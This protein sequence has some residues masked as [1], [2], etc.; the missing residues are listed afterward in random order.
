[1]ETQHTTSAAE[2]PVAAE[3]PRGFQRMLVVTDR[4]DAG[5]AAFALARE[6]AG[7]FG[8]EIRVLEVSEA[9]GATLGARNRHLAE[10]IAEAAR[11]SGA[12]AIV[13]GVDR[14]RMARGHLGRSLRDHLVG[15]TDLPV[16]LAPAVA[17]T[18]GS[19][20][21]TGASEIVGPVGSRELQTAGTHRA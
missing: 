10:G 20:F 4:T 8:A 3:A 5:R 14:Q 13:L 9:R 16:L 18:T 12:D 7:L 21:L 15:T 19:E 1:M 17:T 11:D 6:W 2:S